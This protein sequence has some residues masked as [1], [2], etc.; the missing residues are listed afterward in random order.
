MKHFLC[1]PVTL[2]NEAEYENLKIHLPVHLSK[3]SFPFLLLWN[4]ANGIKKTC[5]FCYRVSPVVK[6]F[7]STKRIVVLL[8]FNEPTFCVSFRCTAQWLDIYKSYEV[9]PTM[10]LAPTWHYARLLQYY[11]LFSGLYFTSPWLFRNC[12]FLLLNPF[13]FLAARDNAFNLQVE[14]LPPPSGRLTKLRS[15]TC[16]WKGF[17][18]LNTSI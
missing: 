5:V 17:L 4:I 8:A 18:F 9:I 3:T 11:W 15:P 13:T 6:N 2:T 16:K 1:Y 12:R 14:A 10:S 7:R